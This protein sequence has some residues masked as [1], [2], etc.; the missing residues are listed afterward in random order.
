MRLRTFHANSMEEAMRQIRVALGD[1]AII[2]STY[3]SRTP[4]T[5]EPKV[6]VVAATDSNVVDLPHT[7]ENDSEDEEIEEI[8]QRRLKERLGVDEDKKEEAGDIAEATWYTTDE[9]DR[10]AAAANDIDIEPTIRGVLNYHGVT[11]RLMEA[12]VSAANALSE[13]SAQQALGAALDARFSFAPLPLNPPRPL[14]LIGPPGSGKSVTVAK[15]AAQAVLKGRKT[16]IVSTDVQ[17]SGAIGQMEIFANVMGLPVLKASSGPELSDFLD[18]IDREEFTVIDTPGTNPYDFRELENLNKLIR[19][20][21]VEPILT[22]DASTNPLESVDVARIFESFGVRRLIISRVDAARRLGGVLMAA[23]AGE[24][25]LA[26]V[27]V[28]PVLADGLTSVQPDSLASL[29]LDRPDRK[30][31]EDFI[32]RA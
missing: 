21:K 5:G 8:L 32:A 16:N 28:S 29:F 14:M 31:L 26:H 15:L 17:R 12:L 7:Q 13:G 4:G 22:L 9:E 27:S 6:E 23:D 25:R 30:D 18:Q 19:G 11:G 2:V 1:E 20:V 10:E 3:R 24:L